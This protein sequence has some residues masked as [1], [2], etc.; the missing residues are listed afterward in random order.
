M[1]RI[2]IIVVCFLLYIGLQLFAQG[3]LTTGPGGSDA[4]MKEA[5]EVFNSDKNPG[6]F[7]TNVGLA[8]AYSANGEYKKALELM[9]AALPQVPHPL[10]KTSVE[11]MIKNSKKE[12]M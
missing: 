10:N 2:A 11:A 5:L 3:Q 12:R 7:T 6:Q 9:K 1:K 4:L 8:R